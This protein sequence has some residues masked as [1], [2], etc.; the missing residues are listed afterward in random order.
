MFILITLNFL[1]RNKTGICYRHSKR[2]FFIKV[3]RNST[4]FRGIQKKNLVTYN[5]IYLIINNFNNYF[6]ISNNNVIKNVFSKVFVF[7][8]LKNFTY[9]LKNY[10]HS[11]P[12]KN[13][14]TN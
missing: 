2:V 12:T 4:F 3:K 11:F 8:H 9:E 14:K 5:L 1:K 6:Y 10:L 13:L 7:L